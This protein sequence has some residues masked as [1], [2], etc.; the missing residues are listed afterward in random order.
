M[1]N[2]HR[3]RR[4][5]GARLGRRPRATSSPCR[6]GRSRRRPRAEGAAPCCA[7]RAAAGRSGRGAAARGPWSRG[8]PAGT[9]AA[10]GAATVG[11]ISPGTAGCGGHGHGPGGGTVRVGRRSRDCRRRRSQEWWRH[12]VGRRVRMPLGVGGGPRWPAGGGAPAVGDAHRSAV[13]GTADTRRFPSA[14]ITVPHISVARNNETDS[15]GIRVRSSRR[16]RGFTGRCQLFRHRSVRGRPRAGSPHFFRRD[17]GS[18]RAARRL[19]RG[20]LDGLFPATL[21]STSNGAHRSA[22]ARGRRATADAPW[23]A[24]VESG[25]CGRAPGAPCG[26]QRGGWRPCRTGRGRAELSVGPVEPRVRRPPFC[27]RER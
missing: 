24:V 8:M 4:G 7:G 1:G 26:G 13:P 9:A 16:R 14:G 22:G 17:R 21:M 20:G 23:G 12:R 3:D 6:A 5:A 2:R 11:G 25:R 15:A 18:P 10:E 27:A 19:R